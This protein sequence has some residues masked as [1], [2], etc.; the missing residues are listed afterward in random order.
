MRGKYLARQRLEELDRLLSERDKDILRSLEN[1]RYLM[2]GQIG[3][4]CFAGS[5]SQTAALR[6]ANRAMTRFRDCGVAEALERRIGGA[7]AGSGSYVWSL[8]ESGVFLLHLND[9]DFS[10]RK[11]LVEPS[12]NCLKHSLAVSETFIQLTEICRRHRLELVKIEL[13]PQCWR[14]YT[15]E[16]GKPATMK[17]DLF[18]VTAGGKYED[19]WF[20]EVDMN[21]ESPSIV[22]E[23]CRRYAR[24]YKSGLEQKQYGVFPLVVWIVGSESRKAKLQQYIAEC[25]E[26]SEQSKGI[27]TVILPDAFEPLIVGGAEAL[28][29]KEGDSQ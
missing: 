28:N 9:A 8:T 10:Q 29:E 7:R 22:L 25:R 6:A 3:R 24:Y 15:G 16:D 18:A 5:A 2:T 19:S 27:F 20:L 13:E 4:L 14:G 26:I 1:C 12:L 21:T 23:K 17:P 11:R